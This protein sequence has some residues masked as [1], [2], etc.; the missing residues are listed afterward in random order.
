MLP[1]CT[2]TTEDSI[3]HWRA[4]VIRNNGTWSVIDTIGYNEEVKKYIE[5]RIMSRYSDW[6]YIQ[7]ENI[8][9]QNDNVS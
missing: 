5:N 9:L 8:Q 1:W 4:V 7:E 3:G 2:E 6:K